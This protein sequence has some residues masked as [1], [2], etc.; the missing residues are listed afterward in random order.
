MIKSFGNQTTEDIFYG[1]STKAARKLSPALHKIAY[2]KLDMLDAASSLT[3]LLMPP[4][5]HLE[6][7]KGNRKGKHSIRINDQWRV[8]FKW[9]PQGPTDVTIEDYH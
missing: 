7:L 8:V 2:R 5:N 1:H 4:N 6:A 9:T 3:D